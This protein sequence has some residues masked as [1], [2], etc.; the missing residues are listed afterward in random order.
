MILRHV[1]TTHVNKVW[2][3]AKPLIQKA[4]DY[5]FNEATIDDIHEQ[6]L[7]GRQTLW[8]GVEA[9]ELVCA[10]TSSF[11]VY[12][13]KNVLRI[14][15]FAT[16]SGYAEYLKDLFVQMQDYGRDNG[17]D[18]IETWSRKGLSKQINWDH[19]Y[20]VYSKNL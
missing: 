14:N 8:L 16:V 7:Q 20:Y 4:L 18:V 11:V 9:K 5:S 19:Q 3:S 2:S 15:F 1:K 13:Q 17:C 12:P 10:G 6:V